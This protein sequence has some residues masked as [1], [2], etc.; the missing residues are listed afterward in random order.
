M[1][2]SGFRSSVGRRCDAIVASAM[3][4]VAVA[5][6]SRGS[7]QVRDAVRAIDAY[8]APYVATNNFSGQLLVIR[9][10][11]V[12]YE[13]Q[14]GA[15]SRE[16]QQPNT[17]DTRFHIASVSMQLTAAAVMR[18]VDQG[19]LTLD[20]HVS[21]IVA[22][23]RGG[24]RITIRNL[25]EMRSGLSDINSRADYAGILQQHQT[26]AS[27][28]S[29]I[30]ND[31]LS[32]APGSRYAHEE[33][34]AYN[35]LALIIEK[36]TGLSFARAMQ[37]LLFAPAGMS[38]SGVDDDMPGAGPMAKG[39]SPEGVYGL[40]LAE[41]IHWSAKSGN[42]S[43]YTTASDE[44]R[45]IRA[46]VHG[47]LLSP[48]ARAIVLD[49]AGPPVGYGWFRRAN[50]RFGEFVYSMNGRSPGFASAV[51]YLP[52]EDLT[53]V[54]FSNI[55]SSAT[56]DI[57]YDVAAI[58]LGLPYTPL[59]IRTS[60]LPLDSLALT[61]A[62][63]AF[64]KDFYQPNAVL[65]FEATGGELFLRWP[66]GDATPIIPVDANHMIDRSYWEPI[67]IVRDST[68]GATGITYDRFSGTRVVSDRDSIRR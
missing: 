41:P 56:S 8:V 11:A 21:E 36:K 27:L 42:A 5:T 48:S 65:R 19:A 23:V 51:L 49:T 18:L 43:A 38:R 29:A 1:R 52:R 57:A 13:R 53:V 60:P 20:T 10:S 22:S 62:A 55:Y 28:V 44:T 25:L 30:S 9:G 12:L 3:V 45:W 63:F 35:L 31:T 40:K 7:A 66:S 47:T 34:S 33:H 67:V 39:Y 50:T 15:A 32:F 4:V 61:G 2:L 54:A 14:F 64:P 68:N 46:L 16:L 59:A 17:R 6:P 26:P 37:R 58:A 24:D